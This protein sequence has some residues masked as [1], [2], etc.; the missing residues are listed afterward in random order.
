MMNFTNHKRV[1]PLFY[2]TISY[3]Y[4]IKI[5]VIQSNIFRYVEI[6]RKA[7]GIPIK[8]AGVTKLKGNE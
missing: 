2:N 3:L 1:L 8:F 6:K 4:P 5:K 7:E